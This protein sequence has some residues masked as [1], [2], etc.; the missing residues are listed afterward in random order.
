MGLIGALRGR[1]VLLAA[2]AGLLAVLQ[3]VLLAAS[4]LLHTHTVE[5]IS[6]DDLPA[7]F[8]HHDF[9]LSEGE[10]P[11]P[12]AADICLACRMERTPGGPPSVGPTLASPDHGLGLGSILDA[13]VRAAGPRPHQPRA[14]PSA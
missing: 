3:S 7:A 4:V 6:I 10:E 5:G 8:H 13:P 12:P 2:W 1:P 9:Q 11:H 14:P